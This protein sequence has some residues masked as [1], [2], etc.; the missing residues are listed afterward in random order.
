[1][2]TDL[3]C[4]EILFLD[5]VL[6]AV[7]NSWVS[8][9][10]WKNNKDETWNRKQLLASLETQRGVI[11]CYSP[12]YKVTVCTRSSWNCWND[13]FKRKKEKRILKNY[14]NGIHIFCEKLC[15]NGK[16]AFLRAEKGSESGFRMKIV[17]E[18]RELVVDFWFVQCA[19]LTLG[20]DSA[21]RE[22]KKGS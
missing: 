7:I 10:F 18:S 12:W 1:M 6:K 20:I 8:S 14:A 21:G 15:S 2:I 3:I 4:I 9:L 13:I 16:I 17:A 5:S 11:F 22:C 19:L